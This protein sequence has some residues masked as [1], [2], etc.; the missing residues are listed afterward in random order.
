MT[1]LDDDELRRRFTYHPPRPGQPEVYRELRD[2]AHDLA[3]LFVEHAP[4][5]RELSLALTNVE[6][7]VMWVNAAIAR[8]P[9]ED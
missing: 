6:Q 5:S 8:H 1:M 3:R 9:A 4:K 7:A 2:A